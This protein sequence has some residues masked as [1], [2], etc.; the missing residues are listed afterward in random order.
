MVLIICWF[1]LQHYHE[2]KLF[3]HEAHLLFH[4]VPGVHVFDVVQEVADRV[5]VAEVLAVLIHCL[6]HLVEGHADLQHSH[7]NTYKK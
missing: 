7:N 6:Q 5:H 1:P 3:D 4:A 2:V